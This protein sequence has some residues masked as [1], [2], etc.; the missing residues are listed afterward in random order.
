MKIK[1]YKHINDCVFTE[2]TE[3]IKQATTIN[4]ISILSFSNDHNNTPPSP[5]MP[6]I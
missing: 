2:T 5:K 3:N 1:I 6:R 4:F